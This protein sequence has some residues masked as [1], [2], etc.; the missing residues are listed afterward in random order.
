VT[1]V[2]DEPF[3]RGTVNR[4]ALAGWLEGHHRTWDLRSDRGNPVDRSGVAS[5]TIEVADPEAT[6]AVLLASLTYLPIL[7]GLIGR[8]PG[9]LDPDRYLDAWI[10]HAM[11]TV[12]AN[13]DDTDT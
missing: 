2:L 6:A 9:D 12:L 3:E 8:T 5:G 13:P 11:R 10:D 7:H 4:V 1:N